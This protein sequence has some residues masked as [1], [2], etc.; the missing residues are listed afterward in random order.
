MVDITNSIIAPVTAVELGM[1]NF[2][3]TLAE[4]QNTVELK[5]PNPVPVK[6]TISPGI[7]KETPC[8]VDVQHALLETC[9]LKS[10]YVAINCIGLLHAGDGKEHV[11]VDDNSPAG[12]ANSN[13]DPR[14]IPIIVYLR[15]RF[16][17]I[18]V[19]DI[20]CLSF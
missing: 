20:S 10:K 9:L 17:S 5:L 14:S 11:N 15:M 3:I 6:G 19:L 13:A 7:T 1:P 2:T 18:L 8:P 12:R 16:T 4:N